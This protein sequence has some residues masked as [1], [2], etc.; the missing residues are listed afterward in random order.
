MTKFKVQSLGQSSRGKC[1]VISG[2]ISFF[3][4]F[5]VVQ[6]KLPCQ[7]QLHVV[8]IPHRHVTDGQ[9]HDDSVYHVSTASRGKKRAL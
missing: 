7:N 4:N 5:K 8:F 9:T 3:Y 6:R 1:T 2:F